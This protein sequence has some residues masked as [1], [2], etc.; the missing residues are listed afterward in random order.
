MKLTGITERKTLKEMMDIYPDTFALV[1]EPEGD[2]GERDTSSYSGIF[3]AVS[4][5]LKKEPEMYDLWDEFRKKRIMTEM[6]VLI[7]GPK[8][9]V[10]LYGKDWKK[11]WKR[12]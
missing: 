1:L 12:F 8:W 5:D 10:P 7:P 6:G 3:Y 9:Y 4:D 11:Y 2:S